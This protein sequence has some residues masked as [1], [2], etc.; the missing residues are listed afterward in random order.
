MKKMFL[1]GAIVMTGVN[2]AMADD[3]VDLHNFKK[4]EALYTLEAKRDGNRA[5][6]KFARLWEFYVFTGKEVN[7][8]KLVSS[9]AL[10]ETFVDEGFKLDVYLAF[11][12]KEPKLLKLREQCAENGEY[13]SAALRHLKK[14]KKLKKAMKIFK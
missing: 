8:K 7:K 13:Y 4:C 10:D 14:K 5:G 2:G 12:P 9:K 3:G 1:V 11:N 6:S